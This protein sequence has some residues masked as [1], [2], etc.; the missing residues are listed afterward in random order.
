MIVI[1]GLSTI[2]NY[3]NFMLIFVRC[4]KSIGSMTSPNHQ[5]Y[6]LEIKKKSIK[7]VILQHLTLTNKIIHGSK[8]MTLYMTLDQQSLLT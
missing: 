8:N 5:I 4:Q 6:T 1:H 2:L 3:G 7:T